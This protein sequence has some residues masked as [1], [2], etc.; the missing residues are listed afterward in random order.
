MHHD[1]RCP[2]ERYPLTLAPYLP[3]RMHAHSTTIVQVTRT[4]DQDQIVTLTF[5]APSF[6]LTIQNR[7]KEGNKFTEPLVDVI[8]IA[9]AGA[10]MNRRLS[11]FYKWGVLGTLVLATKQAASADVPQKDTGL[12][13]V[14]LL[15]IPPCCR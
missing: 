1:Q 15:C 6:P 8:N 13:L 5:V 7:K 3:D 9:G 10:V 11:V 2:V 14:Q 12:P 4:S